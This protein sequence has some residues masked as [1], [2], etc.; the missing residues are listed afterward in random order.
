M[1]RKYV[2]H[3]NQVLQIGK[4]FGWLPG[5]RYTNLRDCKKV[6]G[7]SFLDIDWK[8]YNFEKHLE[9]VKQVRPKLTIAQDVLS[10]EDL[11]KIVDQ[12]FELL[13]FSDDV[14]IVPKD[15]ALSVH[16]EASIPKEFIFAYSVPSRYGGTLIKPNFF[17]RDV[18]LLGG[19]PDI[20]REIANKLKV[21]SM[22]CNRFTYDAKFG[23]YFEG[24][25]F[26]PHPTGGY[27][28]CLE[29]SFKNINALWGNY[30]FGN[31]KTS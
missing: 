8:N 13:E 16:M 11:P 6:G 17:K 12:A 26:R 3:S 23:D 15:V 22:D 10:Q 29:D 21:V 20:Q 25:S 7:P 14:A 2:C 4:K 19:R 5:A 31:P 18:H 30:S 1:I 24:N 28:N 27:I 9:A